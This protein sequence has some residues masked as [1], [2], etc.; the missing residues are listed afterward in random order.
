MLFVLAKVGAS[1]CE[2]LCGRIELGGELVFGNCVVGCVALIVDRALAEICIDKRGVGFDAAV[3][4][5]QRI[6]VARRLPLGQEAERATGRGIADRAFTT[7]LIRSLVDG[8]AFARDLI[9]L[10][11]LC[12]CHLTVGVLEVFL[13]FVDQDEAEIICGR[14]KLRSACP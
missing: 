12:A 13:T 2:N 4:I 3:E 11:E 5:A 8:N 14:R 7:G 10:A 9:C 1:T 6:V